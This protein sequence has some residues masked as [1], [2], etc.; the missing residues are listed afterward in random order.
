MNSTRIF[1]WP[2]KSQVAQLKGEKMWIILWKWKLF[3]QKIEVFFPASFKMKSLIK[4]HFKFKSSLWTH[5]IPSFPFQLL[6]REFSVS[7]VEKHQTCSPG[8]DCGRRRVSTSSHQ[9]AYTQYCLPT[10]ADH[11]VKYLNHFDFVLIY[12]WEIMSF[13]LRAFEKIE[14]NDGYESAFKG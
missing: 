7:L 12:E 5:L 9:Q 11:W 10:S 13:I 1:L 6:Y 2:L 4:L 14:W 3:W 8:A